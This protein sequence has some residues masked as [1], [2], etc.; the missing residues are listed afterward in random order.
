M[1][2]KRL[3]W[4]KFLFIDRTEAETEQ[5]YWNEKRKKHLASEHSAGIV[6]GLEVTQTSPPSLRVN[7]APGRAID[8]EGNDPEVESAQEVDLSSLVPASGS[9][10]A[11][12]TLAFADTE[13]EPYFVEETGQF[14]NKYVQDAFVLEASTTPPAD[15]R[16]ELARVELAAGAT[17]VTD[18]ADPAN[19]GVNEIDITHRD[20]TGKEVLALEDLADV[21][22]D[23][24]AAF[25]GMTA[26]SGTN[27]IGT[28]ADIES[29][30][31]PVRSE[32]QAARGS[33]PSLDARLD[34]A[35]AEDGALKGHAATHRG[36]GSDAI[37]VTTPSIA[38]LMSAADKGK[39]DTVEEGAVAAGEAGDAHAAITTGNPH[40]LDPADVGAAP[41]GHV[42]AGGAAHALAVAGGAAGFMSGADKD[43][44]DGL[45]YEEAAWTVLDPTDGS[46][47]AQLATVE[48]GRRYWLKPGDWTLGGVVDLN[49][50]GVVLAGTEASVVHATPAESAIRLTADRCALCGFKLVHATTHIDQYCVK[51]EAS[52]CAI[53]RV[54]FEGSPSGSSRRS[55]IACGFAS[56][57]CA[58]RDCIVMCGYYGPSGDKPAIQFGYDWLVE[59]CHVS[60]DG[61]SAWDS[62][63]VLI[64]PGPSSLARSRV[65]NNH[66]NVYCPAGKYATA[67]DAAN[68][69]ATVEGNYVS[70]GGSLG[71][72]TGILCGAGADVRGNRIYGC[73]RGI[74]SPYAMSGYLTI[75]DNVVVGSQDRYT[76]T[77]I[78]LKALPGAYWFQN[79][80]VDGNVVRMAETGIGL[81]VT[82]GTGVS[83]NIVISGNTVEEAVDF[84]IRLLG[85]ATGNIIE[86]TA[87]TGNTVRGSDASGAFRGIDVD[88][89]ARG[90]SACGNAVG[91]F[92]GCGI[93][94]GQGCRGCV[95]SGNSVY[96]STSPISENGIRVGG[97][98]TLVN[99]NNMDGHFTGAAIRIESFANSAVVCDNIGSILDG[100]EG[101]FVYDNH[102]L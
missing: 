62:A 100:G 2:L 17:E 60:V 73:T 91:R 42:G 78:D 54:R 45:G 26:P 79:V 71:T 31:A 20:Y 3:K 89:V 27:P 41:A 84:G 82:G 18:A 15:P 9:V 44:L 96:G 55:A 40:Q 35:L 86:R 5:S 34:V 38:G 85:D 24:A 83:G 95:V 101:S 46:L 68:V 23:E 81:C 57:N 30:V 29:S 75:A 52:S 14:Q 7:V 102:A 6:S 70:A 51:V 19:P 49:Q 77:G 80:V 36:D 64:G 1:A 50:P 10:T 65:R 8:A 13:V 59:N 88:A 39:L 53:D 48:A 43:K 61:M 12:V 47:A 99:A 76:T 11:Y 87:V 33:R 22:P 69:G 58:V 94:T 97:L 16:V 37:A 25:N 56:M 92:Q 66:V 21:S 90:V 98:K 67:I 74:Y 63:A 93:R 72:V 4:L 28:L 32:V